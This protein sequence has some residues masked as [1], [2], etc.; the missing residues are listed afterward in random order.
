[1]NALVL[2]RRDARTGRLSE[3][4]RTA[5]GVMWSLQMKTGPNN[6]AWTW[7]NFN[8]EPWESPNS[9]YFGASLA[10]LAVGSAPDGYAASPEIQDRLKALRG[11]F[12]R[13]HG[14]VSVLNQLMGLWA[15]G[16]H[17]RPADPRATSSHDRMPPSRCNRPMAAGA[18]RRLAP[19][20]ASTRRA[21]DTKSDGYAH[22]PRRRWRCRKP[23]SPATIRAWRR[24]RL[25]APQPGSR[26][27]T[28]DRD[29]AQQAT[30]SGIR[31]R[32]IHERRR[33]RLRRAGA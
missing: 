26:H 32:P 14:T 29:I 4:T 23:A 5:L 31:A 10:A 17:S 27:R 21:N 11:Y 7:L 16:T 18:P 8:Y 15:S 33:H 20:S 3:D 2:S 22:G 19:T 12:E 9:P 13:Q 28:M 6:G 24:A 25:A 1:M 30:R